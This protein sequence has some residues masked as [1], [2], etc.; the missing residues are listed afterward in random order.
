MNDYLR[1][2]IDDLK[3]RR[4]AA[5]VGCTKVKGLDDTVDLLTSL[6]NEA[7]PPREIDSGTLLGCDGSSV[8]LTP[9]QEDARIEALAMARA[10]SCASAGENSP[11]IIPG[12]GSLGPVK[13]AGRGT[14]YGKRSPYKGVKVGKPKQDGSPRYEAQVYEPKTRRNKYLGSFDN[15]LEAAL[16]SAKCGDDAGEIERIEKL[17]R[18][19]AENNPNRPGAKTAEPPLP[20]AR[21]LRPGLKHNYP[22]K[23]N[24]TGSANEQ[25]RIAPIDPAG[26]P[27]PAPV[28]V[29][30]TWECNRC[31]RQIVSAERPKLCAHCLRDWGFTA[32]KPRSKPEEF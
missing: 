13:P 24:K 12:A 29:D 2:T 6:N 8:P 9:V 10:F 22:K 3:K 27:G 32:I 11:E 16:A 19:Q 25:G 18:Q 20:G 21:T 17:I 31:A 14:R 23:R 5:C 30:L 4:A 7:D 26:Q 15:E 28:H 1:L